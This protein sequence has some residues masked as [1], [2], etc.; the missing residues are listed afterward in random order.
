M[1]KAIAILFVAIM[2]VTVLSAAETG[3]AM[4]NVP[5]NQPPVAG[6]AG[7]AVPIPVQL[8]VCPSGCNRYGTAICAYHRLWQRCSCKGGGR[9][10][11]VWYRTNTPC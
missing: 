3:F 9:L 6:R 11:L 1:K 10:R 8:N 7:S 4:A 5:G 2:A